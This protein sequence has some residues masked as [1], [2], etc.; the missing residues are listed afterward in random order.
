VA[1]VTPS[2]VPQLEFVEPA[3][4]YG[5]ETPLYR[6]L[7]ARFDIET[8]SYRGRFGPEDL[9]VRQSRIG[10]RAVKLHA[11][12]PKQLDNSAEHIDGTCP[13]A[14]CTR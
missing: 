6:G 14:G 12:R 3:F 11:P 7:A 13:M 2:I 5:Q 10:S 4:G 9:Q 8:R 1:Q